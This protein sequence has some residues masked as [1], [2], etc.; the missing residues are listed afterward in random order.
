MLGFV[1]IIGVIRRNE[2]KFSIFKIVEFR[3]GRSRLI[4]DYSKN[5]C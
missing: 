5:N 2:V 4:R 1:L 3:G